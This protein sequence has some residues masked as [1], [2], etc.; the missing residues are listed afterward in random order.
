[1]GDSERRWIMGEKLN[2][3]SP[4]AHIIANLALGIFF[5]AASLARALRL[6]PL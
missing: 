1:M 3:G 4:T 2:Y 5:F 6:N